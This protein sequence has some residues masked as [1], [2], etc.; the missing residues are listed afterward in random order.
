MER[1]GGLGGWQH[2]EAGEGMAVFSEEDNIFV[3][4]AYMLV[5]ECGGTSIVT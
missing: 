5:V 2:V 1:S 4:N 3:F